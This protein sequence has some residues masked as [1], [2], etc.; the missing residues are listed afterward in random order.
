[1]R[2]AAL[3]G[4]LFV[5]IT[6]WATT[7]SSATITVYT[8]KMEWQNALGEECLTED[9]ADALLNV[10]VS[11]VSTESGHINPVQE[12]YQDVL[13]SQSQN[14]PMTT[15]TFEPQITAYGGEWTLGGPGGS[16]NS[17]SV[18]IADD[19]HYVGSIPNSYNGEFWGFISDTPFSSV[20]LVGG[21][22]TNQ[23]HY[24]LD[25]MVYL[26]MFVPGNVD[27][28]GP[29]PATSGLSLQ[30]PSPYGIDQPIRVMGDSAE[31]ASVGIFDA[32]GRLLRNLVAS[33]RRDGEAIF[34]WDGWTACGQ[35]AS[36]SALFVHAHGGGGTITR[37]VVL[38]R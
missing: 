22:G 33:S 11:Y 8:D 12:C 5:T 2:K 30:V 27:P 28:L 25:D 20:R 3:L 36:A 38:L 23:Q 31:E 37:M 4:T 29:G 13:A 34:C 18:Y 16:G 9:F 19:S 1:M 14:D 10:G 21:T 17:L 32:Q 15:W 24:C 7:V 26:P 35:R 6:C